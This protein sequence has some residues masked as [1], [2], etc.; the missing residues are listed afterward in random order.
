M[1]KHLNTLF[2]VTVGA[3]CHDQTFDVTSQKVP[4]VEE[5]ALNGA[6]VGINDL[7]ENVCAKMVD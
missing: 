4:S 5:K 6:A 3:P 2:S 7:Q 1:V